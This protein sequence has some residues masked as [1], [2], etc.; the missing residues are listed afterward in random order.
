MNSA[1]FIWLLQFALIQLIPVAH[2]RQFYRAYL[3]E[4]R[5]ELS[6]NNESAING[7]EGPVLLRNASF[8]NLRQPPLPLEADDVEAEHGDNS[9]ASERNWRND[10][11]TVQEIVF[12]EECSQPVY[13]KWANAYYWHSQKKQNNSHKRRKLFFHT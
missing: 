12:F 10:G 9:K 3:W 1:S 4:D 7:W 8:L 6:K 13:Q 5:E 11:L 2:D